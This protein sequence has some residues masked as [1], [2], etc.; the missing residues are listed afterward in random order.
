M[1]APCRVTPRAAQRFVHSVEAL[2][3]GGSRVSMAATM[4]GPLT[5]V[6]SRLFGR[7]MAGYYPTAV[8]QLVAT[9]EGRPFGRA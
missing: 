1:L 5:P 3:D 2:P 4:D 9:A 8:R 7:I 6:L